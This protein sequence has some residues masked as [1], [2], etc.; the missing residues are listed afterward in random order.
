[1]IGSMG[2]GQNLML[3]QHSTPPFS[4]H[5]IMHWRRVRQSAAKLAKEFDIRTSSLDTPISTLSGGN[6][7]MVVLARELGLSQPKIII[8]MNPTRGLDV[9]ATRFVHQQLLAHRARGA[10]ILLIS[11]ELDEVLQLGDR[12]GVLFNGRL[13]MS[14][15]PRDGVEKIGRLMA[16][17]SA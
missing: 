3:K 7:H 1:L 11:S 17:V 13:T 12:V 10:A 8:A 15:F 9:A 14:D 2:I 6:Q 16:G 5:G 4:H